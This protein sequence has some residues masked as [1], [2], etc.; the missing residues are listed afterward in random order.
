MAA[1]HPA[2]PDAYGAGDSFA[3]AL[4]YALA[5][6]M[7]IPA[8]I[9]LAAR[10]GS[11]TA[12]GRGPYTS[13]L[14]K[15]DIDTNAHAP[16]ASAPSPTPAYSR[17][18]RGDVPPRYPPF[19]ALADELARVA[20]APEIEHFPAGAA[21]LEQSGEPARF[22]YVVRKGAVELIAEGRLYDLLSDGEVF[23]QFSLL[24]ARARHRPYVRTRTPSAT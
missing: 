22:L 8:A 15:A 1:D 3:A 16:R 6:G 12:Y 10:A 13:Q 24:A 5:V 19:D 21:I 11:A 20:C 2:R 4:A 18:G 7:E 14:T 17:R 23:G 9:K